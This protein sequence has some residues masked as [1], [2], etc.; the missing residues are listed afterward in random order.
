MRLLIIIA[1]ILFSGLHVNAQKHKEYVETGNARKSLQLAQRL[2]SI[3]QYDLAKKQLQYTIK[4]KDDFAVA[5]RELGVVLMQLH[6]F[7]GAI[8]AYEKSFELDKKLSRAAFYECGESYFRLGEPD[9][10]TEYFEKFKNYSVKNYAN[11]DK[12]SGLEFTYEQLLEERLKKYGGEELDDST[13]MKQRIKSG[14]KVRGRKVDP[15]FRSKQVKK[16]NLILLSV[17]AILIFLSYIFIVDYL[18]RIIEVFDTGN[19][20]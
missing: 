5:Y 12:E 19:T 8:E 17:L 18:P 9:K 10:A 13:L 14:F 15:E 2:I 4:I 7:H 1:S 11:K 20:N 3:H 16:S 6:D